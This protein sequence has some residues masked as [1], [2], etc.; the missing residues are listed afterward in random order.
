MTLP[1]PHMGC[2]GIIAPKGWLQGRLGGKEEMIALQQSPSWTSDPDDRGAEKPS[3]EMK[4]A[5]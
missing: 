3:S 5:H 2:L 1:Y 4:A